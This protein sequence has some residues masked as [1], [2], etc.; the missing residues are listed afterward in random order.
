MVGTECDGAPFAAPLPL[1][2]LLNAQLVGPETGVVDGW[3][4]SSQHRRR[5]TFRWVINRDCPGGECRNGGRAPAPFMT[6][7]IEVE[8]NVLRG[9]G[10]VPSAHLLHI[11]TDGGA[12]VTGLGQEVLW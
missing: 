10:K 5:F 8:A 9:P 3:Q 11:E 6:P 12:H 1:T 2:D 4:D 7:V